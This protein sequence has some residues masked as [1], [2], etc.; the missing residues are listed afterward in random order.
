MAVIV[1]N[2]ADAANVLADQSVY[3]L[4]GGRSKWL[5]FLVSVVRWARMRAQGVKREQA[6][7]GNMRE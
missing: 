3:L 4:T 6:W 2:K 7:N 5:R 1:Q